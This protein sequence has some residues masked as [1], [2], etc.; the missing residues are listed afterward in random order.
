MSV[1]RPMI[2]P[3]LSITII[4]LV[5]ICVY[6]L[7]RALPLDVLGEIRQRPIAWWSLPLIALS[8]ILFWLLAAEIWRRVVALSTGTN[9]TLWSSYLQLA[10]VGVGKYVPGKIWGFVARAGDMYRHR[11]PIHLSA[12][13][14]VVEQVF[15]I[16][17]ALLIAIIAA[18]V[19]LPQYWIVI[20]LV[21]LSLL[22]SAIVA[23]G[24]I[25]AMTR[26]LLR[27][28]NMNGEMDHLPNYKASAVLRFALAYALLW[29]MNGLIFSAVYYSL[30]D[31]SITRE[32]V[33][34]LILANTAGIV[35]GFFAFF[36]P[37]GIGVREAV[38]TF[39]LAGFVPLREALLAAVC[40]RAW[41]ILVDGLNAL[42]IL[43][44]E[45]SGAKRLS[46]AG[47]R[48]AE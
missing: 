20:T 26:W 7:V 18:L 35:L 12:M 6:F 33:A 22:V 15:V 37:G 9:I 17:G 31:A 23:S 1:N 40:Y 11:I 29:L 21:G 28:R 10:V 25:P 32:S 13:S 19:A 47:D 41:L 46:T 2:K 24:R 14:S 30:F 43:G 36:V 48:H 4:L 34:A 5:V 38:A 16:A 45:A 42:L 44:R 3:L 39:V 8:Q 27:R